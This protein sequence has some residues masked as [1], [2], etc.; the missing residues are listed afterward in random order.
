[1][2][3]KVEVANYGVRVT[4][5]SVVLAH[6]VVVTSVQ[7]VRLPS[8][9]QPASVFVLHPRVLPEEA[10][11]SMLAVGLLLTGLGVPTLMGGN[12]AGR[13]LGVGEGL[14]GGQPD[15]LAEGGEGEGG[16]EE[17]PK[18]N[19]DRRIIKVPSAINFFG[20]FQFQI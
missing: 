3:D 5:H 18:N 14:G 20:K 12:E 11:N 9:P 2:V 10:A 1:M 4:T 16:D 17:E 6:H 13:G 7:T 19:H 15:E 8:L